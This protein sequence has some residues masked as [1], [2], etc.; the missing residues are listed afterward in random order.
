MP[1]RWTYDLFIN[2]AWT[3]GHGSNVIDV[4]NPATEELIGQVPEATPKD[5]VR[6]IQ[7]ARKAFD[8]GPWPWMKPRERAA[9]LVKMAEKLLDRL[10][11]VQ[12]AGHSQLD[13][14]GPV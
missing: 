3:P 14:I 9:V 8:E 11:C 5:A 1:P 4:I 12:V 2:G 13:P 7:A 6:A 10:D